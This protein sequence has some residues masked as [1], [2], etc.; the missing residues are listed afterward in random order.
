GRNTLSGQPEI[1]A[2]SARSATSQ[3]HTQEPDYKSELKVKLNKFKVA[4][5]DWDKD[6]R[7]LLRLDETLHNINSLEDKR[8][9]EVLNLVVLSIM[10]RAFY[11]PYNI[12]HFGLGS[13]YYCHFTS[14]IRRYPDTITHRILNSC[15]KKNPKFGL[16]VKK[17]TDGAGTAS[18]TH[19]SEYTTD[20]LEELCLHSSIQSES[21]EKLERTMIDITFALSYML[22]RQGVVCVSAGEGK[23]CQ[24]A[25]SH[26]AHIAKS[27]QYKGTVS[28]I[29]GSSIFVLL[30]T[31]NEARIPISSLGK[32]RLSPDESGAA[33]TITDEKDFLQLQEKG[34]MKKIAPGADADAVFGKAR[35]FVKIGD[36]VR[37]RLKDLDIA[38]GSIIAEWVGVD[39]S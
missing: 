18:P 13:K 24:E 32:V 26:I 14:P 37:I 38:D 7:I 20:D 5:P 2:A 22:S 30:P 11:S 23:S 4:S 15:F 28:S 21:A 17:I 25:K 31:G 8:L 36:R 34:L 10:S 1:I 6:R 16:P 29:T 39:D 3:T 35:V 33:L 27:N 19:E 12:G 9:T